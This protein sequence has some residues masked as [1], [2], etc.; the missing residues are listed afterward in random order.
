MINFL[1]S[2]IN[3]IITGGFKTFTLKIKIFFSIIIVLVAAIFL[4]PFFIIIRSFSNLILIRFGDLPSNRIGHFANDVNQYISHIKKS[5]YRLDFFYLQGPVS[6]YE[7]VKLFKNYLFII[8]K[9]FIAPFIMLNKIKFL[10]NRK[11]NIALIPSVT[12]RD[13]RNRDLENNIYN[14]DKKKI[15]YGNSFLKNIGL[16]K[17]DKFICLIVR[18]AEYLKNHEPS[19]NWDYHN[20]RDCNIDNFKL[21]SNY[22]T[23]VGYYVFRMGAK[24]SNPMLTNNK[25]IIDYATIGVRNEFLD[26]FLS[27]NCEFGISTQLGFDCLIEMFN[28]PLICVSVAPIAQ[29][30]S[31]NKKH[32]TIFKKH[33]TIKNQ[34]SLNLSEIFELNLANA[35][36]SKNYENKGINLIENSPEEIKEAAIEMLKLMQNNFLRDSSQEF[37]ELKFWNIFNKKIK[38]YGFKDLHANFFKAHIGENF[39]KNNMNFLN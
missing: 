6:N 37:L 4:L 9:I 33:L 10:G 19:K 27:A 24:V 32:L 2:Q 13:L 39:L 14:F 17:D 38:D 21:V 31:S 36:D 15:L 26:I 12:G 34:K 5:S 8:P 7:L 35:L 28:K 23:N 30:R 20:Y 25:K 11:H 29:I 18:D 16:N 3:Q 22:L 1:K